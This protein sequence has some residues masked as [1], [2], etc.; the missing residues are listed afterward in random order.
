[1][2]AVRCPGPFKPHFSFC[3]PAAEMDPDVEGHWVS[4]WAWSRLGEAPRPR[5]LPFTHFGVPVLGGGL[6]RKSNS[7]CQ[8]FMQKVMEEKLKTRNYF[9]F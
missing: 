1:M 3:L 2:T 6:Q 9:F 4:C 5:C 7:T 8:G